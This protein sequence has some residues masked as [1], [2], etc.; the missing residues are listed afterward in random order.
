MPKMLKINYDVLRYACRLK[1]FTHQSL[2]ENIIKN[3]WI[4]S[5]AIG[6]FVLQVADWKEKGNLLA[7]SGALYGRGAFGK[8]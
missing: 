4:L 7:L 3:T 5:A 8:V 6:L 1:N 2:W